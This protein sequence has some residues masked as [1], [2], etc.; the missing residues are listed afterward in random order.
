MA[1]R[2]ELALCLIPPSTVV[3]IAKAT[4]TY[5]PLAITLEKVV[6]SDTALVGLA[7]G[8]IV[9]QTSRR[10]QSYLGLLCAA[11]VAGGSSAPTLQNRTVGHG[12]DGRDYGKAG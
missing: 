2:T 8:D 9:Q 10:A 7:Q 4:A 3:P 1:L 5:R 11:A 12:C 6:L